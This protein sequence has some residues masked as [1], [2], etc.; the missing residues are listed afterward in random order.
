[1]LV[2]DPDKGFKIVLYAVVKIG[3]QRVPWTINGGRGGHDF[4]HLRKSNRSAIDLCVPRPVRGIRR[5]PY[6]PWSSNCAGDREN[7]P[8]TCAQREYLHN[9]AAIS[10]R[11]LMTISRFWLAPT[12]LDTA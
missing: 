9:A 8:R 10:C 3:R 2:I 6:L 4:S 11:F 7:T 12:E 1:M 5:D